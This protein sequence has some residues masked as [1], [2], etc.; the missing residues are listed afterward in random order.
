MISMIK[1]W[2]VL[3]LALFFVAGCG[4][5]GI[6]SGYIYNL[7]WIHG[8]RMKDF[9]GK[10]SVIG[11]HE[12]MFDLNHP[13]FD[14]L[15]LVYNNSK[16]WNGGEAKRDVHGTH[17][18]G[19]LAANSSVRGLAPEADYAL[20]SSVNHNLAFEELEAAGVD[21]INSSY[22]MA[23][24][25]GYENIAKK[26]KTQTLKA[27]G[28]TGI[29]HV[30]AAGNEGKHIASG[31]TFPREFS[32]HALIVGELDEGDLTLCSNY[33]KD[34]DVFV[35]VPVMTTTAGGGYDIDRGSSCSVAVTVAVVAKVRQLR[36]D[37]NATTLMD[38]ICKTADHI[39]GVSYDQKDANGNM[40]SDLYGCGS[41]NADKFFEAA[42][43]F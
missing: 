25:S 20:T 40:R 31:V 33:G 32:D 23:S 4:N 12:A 22:I 16:P 34:V 15:S 10:G 7:N 17:M 13:A 21:A 5:E 35:Q 26:V 3:V 2:I 24:Y 11:M 9:T 43:A 29:V 18:L 27:H 36:P 14:M 19:I 1:K 8:D 6:P 41:L 38:L 42:E 30:F 28:G 37:L 39:G